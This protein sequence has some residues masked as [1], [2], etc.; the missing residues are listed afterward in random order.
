MRRKEQGQQ[1]DEE[2]WELTIATDLDNVELPA[3]LRECSKTLGLVAIV[4]QGGYGGL[5]VLSAR[6]L[7]F[8]RGQADSFAVPFRLRLRSSHRYHIG[9]PSSAWARIVTMPL[10]SDSKPTEE[11]LQAWKVFENIEERLAKTRQFCVPFVN[12]N[13][14]EAT[15]NITFIIDA[16]SAT[17]DGTLESLIDV[18]DFWQRA[19]RARNQNLKALETIYSKGKSDGRELGTI[20]SIEVESSRIRVRLDSEI[21]DLIS[22][23]LYQLPDTGFLSFE[24][25]G[26]IVQI[27]RKKKAL[28]DLEYGRTQNPY[29]SQFL[30]DAS[31]ARL[32][33]EI[34]TIQQQNLLL[35][36]ANSFQKSAVEIVLAAPDLALIQGPPGTGKTTVI[37]EI[38]YQVALRGGRTLIASQAN[39]AVDNALSRLQ[40]NPVI[41]AVRKGKRGSVAPEGEQFLEDRVIGR[42]LQNTATDCEKN[43]SIHIDNINILPQLLASSQK[44]EAYLNL[45]KTFDFN[46]RRLQ[47]YVN[48]LKSNKQIIENQHNLAKTKQTELEFLLSSLNDLLVSFPQINWTESKV[49]HLFVRLQPYIN[50]HRA[51]QNLAANLHIVIEKINLNP[52][53]QNLFGKAA[54]VNNKVNNVLPEVRT[55]LNQAN[56]TVIKMREVDAANQ[57]LQQHHRDLIHLRQNYNNS[58]SIQNSQHQEIVSLQNRISEIGLAVIE[59]DRWLSNNQNLRQFLYNFL[60]ERKQLNKNSIELSPRLLAL[61]A[62][63][64]SN[65]CEGT[66]QDFAEKFNNLI[67]TYRQ[68]DQAYIIASKLDAFISSILK[69]LSTKPP[70]EEAISKAMKALSLKELTSLSAL[71]KLRQLTHSCITELEKPLGFLAQIMEFI[72]AV[73]SQLKLCKPSRRTTAMATLEA[74]K[75]L[76]PI[77]IQK[78]QPSN[79]DTVVNTFTDELV[80]TIIFN[81]RTWLN[82]LQANTQ[83]RMEL[84]QEQFDKQR[85]LVLNLEEQISRTEELIATASTNIDSQLHQ[86][87]LL[88]QRLSNLQYIPTRLRI[89]IENYQHNPKASLAQ[90]AEFAAQLDSWEHYINEIEQL[91]PSLNPFS[92]LENIKN[93]IAVEHTQQETNTK[94]LLNQLQ[95]SKQK[96]SNIDR[97]LQQ[98][99]ENLQKERN[100]WE[101]YWQKIPKEFKPSIP[102]NELFNTIF[103][104]NFQAQFPVWQHELENSQAYLQRYQILVSDWITKLHHPTEQDR[105][106]LQRI[107]LDNANVIGITCSQSASRDFSEEFKSFDVVIIDEVSKCTPPELLIPALKA[108]KLI[109]VGDHRQLP[110]MLDT[111]T[112]E[113]IAEE[114]GSTREEISYLEESLFKSLFEQAQES[115]KVMLNT[116]YRMHPMIMGAI[117]QFYDNQL[118]CGLENPDKQRAHNFTNSIIQDNKHIVWVKTPIQQGFKEQVDGTSFVNIKEVD[119]IEKLC[120]QFEQIW[121]SKVK[122]GQPRKEI[123]IITFY[124][125]QIKLIEDRIDIRRYPSLHIRTGTVDRFQGMER[126]IIIVSMVRNNGQGKVGFAK[127]PERVNVAFSRAQELLVIVGC[128]SLFTQQHGSVGAIYS[129]V[130]N[131]VRING[132]FIDVSDILC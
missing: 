54:W 14:G 57:V 71:Q 43:L 35:K 63:I 124:G 31:K 65:P 118:K 77:I 53:E 49:S 34:I 114:L 59:L 40:H 87:T 16:N 93:E 24:A 100:W 89:L 94:N 51:A 68:W 33:Q 107:Y 36:T 42:W 73:A 112:L 58:F 23:G 41:R 12:H 81:A 10:L 5:K 86:V 88:W 44:F 17:V 30:F 8:N 7:P 79:I 60:Q 52:T 9:V 39:L 13:Y 37:A 19:K 110:P 47:E 48:N 90:V 108:K 105:K 128:H 109:L 55:A 97:Q 122:K 6:L 116:Q 126:Q 62:E 78:S 132:G 92:V 69:K 123:G 95:E 46:Q 117:N 80:N 27:K 74:V 15:R 20:E 98:Q 115:I 72:L 25:A 18:D 56:N 66:L 91:I 4:S 121:S 1:A 3:I 75:R 38:C 76:A 45:E 61:F 28:Q 70:S 26:D 99:Q 130:S 131:I 111:N 64:K 2:K 96:L 104:Q 32:P 113:E 29:L 125:R 50:S 83:H 84:L 21:F 106:E 11:Q 102:S 85:A 120:D 127:K 82:D 129:N 101:Q 119:I 22:G 67:G 103:L